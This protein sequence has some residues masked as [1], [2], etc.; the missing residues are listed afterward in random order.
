MKR[1]FLIVLVLLTVA[2]LAGAQSVPNPVVTPKPAN[3]APG[4]LS[5][6]YIFF[7]TNLDLAARGYVEQEFFFEGTTNTYNVSPLVS[8]LDTATIT[9]SGHHYLTRMVVRRPLSAEDFNGTVLMEWQN[10]SAGYEPDALW[11]ASH[12]YIMQRGYAWIG[13]SVQRNGIHSPVTG[14][15]VWSPT[16]YGALDVT[17]GNTVTN[18]GLCWDIF[19]QAGQA[20]RHPQGVDPMG[21][22]NVERIF[23]VGWSQSAVRLIAYHN[24]IHPLANIFDAF[25]LI[26]VDGQ[27][28]LPLRTDLDVKVFKVL[29]ETTVAGNQIA[30]SQALLR[31]QEQNMNPDHF[32]RWEVAG[33]AQLD[34]YDT[35]EGAPLQARDLP[36]SP[37]LQCNLPPLS[38]IPFYF[39]V[40]AAYDHMVHWVKHNVAPPIG[41][42]I[43]VQTF[44]PPIAVLARDS[45]GNALGG[46][47]L[48]QHAVPTAT[49]TGVN[50][51]VATFCRY[52]GSYVPFDQTTLDALYP[53][54]QAYLHLVI[55][56][57]HE[58]K[59]LGFIT[60]EDAAATIREAAKSDIGRK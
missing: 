49:N 31:S 47:R 50:T 27:A 42:D 3:V 2:C 23:A 17:D 28:L 20:V 5:H 19:S 58:N 30:P 59:K 46:I 13:V 33:A 45:F 48:S 11:I 9:S 36:L 18:D 10:V 52:V 34:Y 32:R 55:V 38:R 22:L 40:N 43:E 53:N 41:S 7:A 14:L 60:G 4:D 24:S 29:N 12:Q 39:V 51:P 57:T 8:K 54:H 26:G 37:P 15:K 1:V 21:G 6:D 44:S 56:A 16:R 25:G 35:Q